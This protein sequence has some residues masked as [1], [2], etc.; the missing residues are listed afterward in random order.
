MKHI[1]LI[2]FLATTAF[3]SPTL[4]QSGDSGRNIYTFSSLLSVTQKIYTLQA[5]DLAGYQLPQNYMIVKDIL[6]DKVVLWGFTYK[7][8]KQKEESMKNPSHN[9]QEKPETLI[10]A[11]LPLLSGQVS[12]ISQK[13]G[14]KP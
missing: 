9:L 5:S 7:T 1:L 11:N 13:S 3:A 2:V 12:G 14:I 10:E 8:E 6:S 4:A